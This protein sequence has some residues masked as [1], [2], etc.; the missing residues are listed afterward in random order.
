MNAKY[1]DWSYE[2]LLDYEEQLYDQELDGENVWFER[3][4]VLWEINL[5]KHKLK[6]VNQS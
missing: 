4:K 5:R 1:E 2:R 6:R 3:D